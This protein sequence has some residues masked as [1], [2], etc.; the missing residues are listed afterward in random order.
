MVLRQCCAIVAIDPCIICTCWVIDQ[1]SIAAETADA[2]A[3]DAAPAAKRVKTEDASAPDAAATEADVKP[4]ADQADVKTEEAGEADAGGAAV[5]EEEPA[6]AAPAA[7]V[8]PVT[9]G[10]R[11]FASGEECY[12]YFHELLVKLRPDQDL[13]EVRVRMHNHGTPRGATCVSASRCLPCSTAPH[14]MQI[15]VFGNDSIC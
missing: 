10:F 11:I 8:D 7:A 15:C 5:K 4:E 1:L 12:S 3:A 6:A 9:L 13:N 2:A 14:G